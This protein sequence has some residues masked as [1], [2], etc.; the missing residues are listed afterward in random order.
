MA[1]EL[2]SLICKC[3]GSTLDPQTAKNGVIKCP[4]C[5]EI[6]TLAKSVEPEALDAIRIGNHELDICRFDDAFASFNKAARIDPAEPEAYI[7]MAYATHKVQHIRDAVSNRLQPICHEVSNKV[8]AQDKNYLRA[9]ALATQE[10]RAQYARQCE[11][12]DYIRKEFFKFQQSGLNYDCFICVKVTDDERT[13][14]DGQKIYTAD[15]KTADELYFH[16]SGKGYKPF[17]SEREIGNRT[18]AD[19]EA[20]ILYALYSSECML[21]VCGNES[22]LQTA[23]VKNEYTRF[24]KMVADD[25]KESDSVAIVFSGSPI[26]RLPGRKGK[27]QGIDMRGVDPYGKI[28]SFVENHTPEAKLKREEAAKRKQRE[29]EE[30]RKLLEELRSARNN[31]SH[32]AVKFCA[33]CG[34]E[35]SDTVKF[36]G[37]CG[38]KEFVSSVKE[39]AELVRKNAEEKARAEYEKRVAASKNTAQTTVVQKESAKPPIP[40]NPDFDIENGV[41]K[42]YN[43]NGGNV[44]IPDNVTSI[45]YK[46]FYKCDSLTNI[47]IPNS[48]T[49][50]EKWAFSGCNSLTS[51]VIPNSVTSIESHVF[52]KCSN[53][54]NI[55]IP[56]SVTTIG[57]CAFY[58]CS[59]TSITIPNSVTSIRDGAFSYCSSLTSIVIPN[60]VTSIRDNA[61]SYCSSLTSITIPDSVMTIGYNAFA[62][63]SNLST[64]TMPNSVTNIGYGAFSNCSS[65]TSI[66]I[67]NSVITIDEIVFSYCGSLTN[68]TIPDSVTSIRDGAFSDC[69]SLTSITIPN[70]VTTIGDNAFYNCNKLTSITIPDSVTYIWECAFSKCSSLTSVTMPKTLKKYIKTAFG[71]EH[72]HIEFTFTK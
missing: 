11:E 12:I 33:L 47:I 41:L 17:F 1:I 16:L 62:G 68:V 15:Y 40:S 51:I 5:T 48:V 58:E 45:G 8:F 19:Y 46:A 44:T 2:Q 28:T 55:T 3:C 4:Y 49:T 65:L 27:L 29:L 30:Q 52:Y 67:P 6:F 37:E 9:L 34:A 42:K 50:I 31:E 60:S 57:P 14:T 71:D 7:G 72:K 39:Y 32:R 26:E 38:G 59:L 18:G 23:W 56:N 35:N 64:I 22:Y 69:S 61:F 10:Q 20:L 63:C 54:T 66:I 36:C 53:L 21:V 24:L 70:S 25:E 13:T 43:G